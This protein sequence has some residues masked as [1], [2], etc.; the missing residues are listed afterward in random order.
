MG[1][2]IDIFVASTNV[3]DTV[4]RFLENGIYDLKPSKFTI[5][6]AMDVGESSNFIQKCIRNDLK[7]LKK[8][9]FFVYILRY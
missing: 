4:P 8:R 2:P 7:N 1:L 6:N 5:S 3:N 9:F